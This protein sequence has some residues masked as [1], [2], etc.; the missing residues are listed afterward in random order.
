[1]CVCNFGAYCQVILWIDCTHLL[2]LWEGY[3][4]SRPWEGFTA[5]SLF[6]GC[7]NE[8]VGGGGVRQEVEQVTPMVTGA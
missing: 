3:S 1:M 5:G 6:E 4:R 7:S 2:C 8:A